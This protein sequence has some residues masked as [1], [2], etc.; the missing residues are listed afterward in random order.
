MVSPGSFIGIKPRKGFHRYYEYSV[1]CFA[2]GLTLVIRAA[3]VIFLPGQCCNTVP[4]RG[5]VFGL[6]PNTVYQMLLLVGV[7]PVQILSGRPAQ[8]VPGA[9]HN[10]MEF[11]V[12]TVESF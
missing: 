1:Y 9:P 11:S 10:H 12:H 6:V 5:I 8:S 7:L 3:G 2:G 4:V